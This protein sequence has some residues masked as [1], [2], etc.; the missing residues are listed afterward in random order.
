MSAERQYP[1][2]YIPISAAEG[3]VKVHIDDYQMDLDEASD[4]IRELTA[5]VTCAERRAMDAERA[6]GFYAWGSVLVVVCSFAAI[7]I[8]AVTEAAK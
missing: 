6:M 8:M 2:I 1:R 3:P 5:R 7:V 4:C